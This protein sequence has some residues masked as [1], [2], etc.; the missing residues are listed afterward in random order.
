VTS[1]LTAS[2]FSGSSNATQNA[3]DSPWNLPTNSFGG[4]ADATQNVINAHSDFAT[5]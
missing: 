3:N 4:A 1:D 2:S 5:S